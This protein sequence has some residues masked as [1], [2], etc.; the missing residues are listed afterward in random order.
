MRPTI[1]A[2][3]L[4][5]SKTP[6][7]IQMTGECI[8]SLCESVDHSRYNLRICVV[9]S[10]PGDHGYPCTVVQ[11]PK[12]FSFNASVQAGIAEGPASFPLESLVARNCIL[13]SNND[14]VYEQNCLNELMAALEEV[15]SASPWMPV[16]HNGLHS[17]EQPEANVIPG[18]QTGYHVC[19]WSYAFNRRILGLN[20][21]LTITGLFPKEIQFWYQDNYYA[22]V[23]QLSGVR[24]AI[25]RDANARHIGEQSHSLLKD[26]ND[27]THGM[28]KVYDRRKRELDKRFSERLS[29]PVGK[30]EYLLTVAICSLPGRLKSTGARVI[31]ELSRQAA[32]LPVQILSLTDNKTMSVGEK[33]NMLVADAKGTFISFVDD[34]DEVSQDYVA[35]LLKSIL[36]NDQSDC[37]AFKV[38]VK[39]DGVTRPCYYD[40]ASAHCNFPDKFTRAPNHIC[41]WRKSQLL[42]FSDMNLGE[43]DEWSERMRP[44]C[45]RFYRINE[46]L[47]TYN[48]S[49]ENSETQPKVSTGK[50]EGLIVKRRLKVAV[51]S[52]CLNEQ[53]QIQGY[54][55]S[56]RDADG[57][58]VCDTGSSDDSVSELRRLGATV[59][60]ITVSPWRF[61]TARNIALSLV[62]ADFDVCIK[63]DIDE[64]MDPGWRD[65][66]EK[67]WIKGVTTR[68]E[69]DFNFAPGQHYRADWIHGRNGYSW[70]WPVHEYVTASIK[71]NM[72]HVEAGKLS[73]THLQEYGKE[74][75]ANY[76]PLM[77]K[78]LKEEPSARLY[79]YLGREYTYAKQHNNAIDTL[80]KYLAH[81][82][83][84]WTSERM[85]A[86]MMIAENWLNLGDK[87]LYESW[88][89]RAMHEEPWS[90]E[91]IVELAY[92]LFWA[93]SR[94]EEAY[95]LTVKALRITHR[96]GHSF[97]TER[98][99]NE[100]P[101]HL[102]SQCAWDLGIKSKSAEYLK[103]ALAINPTSKVLLENAE[104]ILASAT[105]FSGDS[106]ALAARVA[107]G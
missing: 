57:V 38:D 101:Y 44:H 77:E 94:I 107:E 51:Y 19:G 3:I 72:V 93:G 79:Y 97:H 102:A 8:S 84:T 62:P 36:L 85:S 41:C 28:K 78:Y 61:D 103:A 56:I 64:R 73:T 48:F 14:V 45:L 4:S 42:K 34:D 83:A 10:H 89:F 88:L 99:W 76:L 1:D 13:I 24:H 53:K 69:Y 47:Y 31:E 58:F 70:K 71:E 33:R 26:R 6:E 65:A 2:I 23:L 106:P 32:G 92:Q 87:G 81:K 18:Y 35:T 39:W 90:R 68:L 17:C 100:V 60:E 63:L 91:P 95:G 9:E 54:M 27:S 59:N 40:P 52:I 104:F 15:D 16:F 11:A 43:D 82:D 7:I 21:D 29:K 55:D 46:S 20:E 49:V 12:P 98:A 67:N 66:I 75:R 105:V 80:T 5:N 74:S 86:A 22:D 50:K 96:Q 37:I 30:G 25:I